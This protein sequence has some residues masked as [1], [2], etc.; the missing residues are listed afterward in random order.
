MGRNPAWLDSLPTGVILDSP[1]FFELLRESFPPS[2]LS[3]KGEA[4]GEIRSWEGRAFCEHFWQQY[5]PRP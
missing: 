4:L 5:A 3:G 1:R 2:A